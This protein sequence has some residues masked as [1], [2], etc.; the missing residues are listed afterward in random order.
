MDDILKYESFIYKMIARY[1]N[2]DKEDLY[3]VAMI[4][5]MNAQKNYNPDEKTKFSTYAYYYVLGE[6]N[7]YIR[8]SNPV[9][10]S[11][12]LLRLKGSLNHAKEI[13]TQRLKREPTTEE[14]AIFLE[15]PQEKIE[16]ALLATSTVES[17]DYAYSEEENN[18]YNSFGQEEKQMTEEVLDLKN[19]IQTLPLEEQK[20]II[21][22]YYE[23]LTQQE[24][25]ESLGITQVQVSRKETKILK[26]LKT[27]L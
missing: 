10:V 20:L 23:G 26:K 25:S 13:M 5:L 24:T 8:A 11:Q 21:A 18:L 3:Q 9:K 17:L 16:E 1:E 7:S 27:T 4:G 12:D 15:E 22:R 19:A 14:L 2:F 6:I